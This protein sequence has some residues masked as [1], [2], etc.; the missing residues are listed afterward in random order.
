V[1]AT[2]EFIARYRVGSVSVARQQEVSRFVLEQDRWLY[3]D[4]QL[5]M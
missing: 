3:V 1:C 2:V 5:K 4:G